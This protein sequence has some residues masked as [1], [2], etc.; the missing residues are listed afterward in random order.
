GG[1]TLSLSW[2]PAFETATVHRFRIW[3][4]G[5]AID[6]LGDGSGMMVVRREPRLE[7]AM[8]DGRMTGA[9]QPEDLRVGD[10]VESAITI[11]RR[12]PAFAG[13]MEILAGLP[14]GLPLGFGRVRMLW[15][16]DAL[17]RHRLL[18]GTPKPQLRRAGDWQE[19]VLSVRDTST[20][21]PPRGA[22]PRYLL[23]NAIEAS[24]ARDWAEISA[25]WHTLYQDAARLGPGSEVK[26]EADA[27]RAA[28]ATD[29][30]RAMAALRLVQDNVRYLALG[31]DGGGFAPASAE[32]TWQRR[33]GDCKGKTAL[34]L[35]LLGELGI[36]AMPVLVNSE[37][38]DALPEMLP[39]LAVF[40]HVL[41]K[42]RIDG[43]D[44]WLDGTR[45]DD[46]RLSD[47]GHAA[48]RHA[49]P[50]RAAGGALVAVPMWQPERPVA[51]FRLDLDARA[52]LDQPAKAEGEARF[53][54]EGAVAWRIGLRQLA[55]ADRDRAMREFW[56]GRHDFVTPEQVSAEEDP[57]TGAHVLRM[58][59]TARLD[60]GAPARRR[61]ETDGSVIGF[62]FDASREPSVLPDAPFAVDHPY[63]WEARQTILLPDSGRG[64]SLTGGNIDE[65][66]G[67]WQFRREVAL[68]GERFLLASS[69]RSTAPEVS[70]AAIRGA[71]P[72][73]R[74]LRTSA[75]W[76]EAPRDVRAGAIEGSA[77]DG[78]PQELL[79]RATKLVDAGDAPAALRLA[80]AA[81]AQHPDSADML[82]AAGIVLAEADA[83]EAQAL[84]QRALERNPAHL[85]ARMLLAELAVGRGDYAG[86]E[87]VLDAVLE[88]VSGFAP[89]RAR[90]SHVRTMLERW[91]A[92]QADLELLERNPDN[93][94]L[95]RNLR[96]YLAG[97][98][99]RLVAFRTSS[100]A[101]EE[102]AEPPAWL[103]HLRARAAL[104][105]GA[106]EDAARLYDAAIAAAPDAALH[107]ERAQ[108][109][110]PEARGG[111][112]AHLRMAEQLD[113]DGALAGLISD[114]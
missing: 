42:A 45:S 90:R 71:E 88:E 3:R 76:I 66:V 94:E 100:G 33:F 37:L 4:D 31:M 6:L 24:N 89:A 53:E 22:P 99:T 49:L 104:G 110:L 39:R 107:L 73:L 8:L 78:S 10:V 105:D 1:G 70:P 27:I 112:Q 114:V 77:E 21:S 102:M 86:A 28:N 72:D 19:L 63:W 47:L 74:R 67:P 11:R 91:D 54:G 87:I 109:L 16:R 81:A 61:Y 50:I 5:R 17:L 41:V 96:E 13:R 51:S 108:L 58:Q 64:F 97:V 111:W 29:A 55:P 59:G 32:Q 68:Q 2:D 40:D 26:K 75:V 82:A 7:Q 103:L 93:A 62:R 14:D 34:L 9:L 43:R 85:N 35:A 30:A 56:R 23:I 83:R 48:F 46:R 106:L 38:G 113:R 36:P 57:E 80:R 60:W 18:P 20:P 84:A 69:V 12:D 25:H 92:A 44:F 15:P 98:Q 95:A 52:G 79:D 65:A 101:M